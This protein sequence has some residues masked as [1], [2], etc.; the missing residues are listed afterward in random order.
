MVKLTVPPTTADAVIDLRAKIDAG[1]GILGETIVD[2]ECINCGQIIPEGLIQKTGAHR[3]DCLWNYYVH[4]PHC[5]YQSNL[6]KFVRNY[7]CRG[8]ARR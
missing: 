3:N 2:F 5:D 6:A 7:K 4:C 1:Q 8:C